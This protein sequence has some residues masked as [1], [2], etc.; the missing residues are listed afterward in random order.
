MTL[1]WSGAFVLVFSLWLFHGHSFNTFPPAKAELATDSGA[2]RPCSPR[3]LLPW[4]V[5]LLRARVAPPAPSAIAVWPMVGATA[6]GLFPL[7]AG[8]TLPVLAL[9]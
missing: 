6:L 2:A 7:A 3:V 9:P 5:R 8:V 4:S 1:L